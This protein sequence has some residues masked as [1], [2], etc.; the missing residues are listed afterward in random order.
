M[1]VETVND[2]LEDGIE[3]RQQAHLKLKPGDDG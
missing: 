2:K 3:R 1:I